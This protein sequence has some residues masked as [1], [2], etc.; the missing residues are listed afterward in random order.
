MVPIFFARSHVGLKRRN[1]EDAY[2][3]HPDGCV[4]AVA[5]GMGGAAA[6]EEA[7]RIFVET[8]KDVFSDLDPAQVPEEEGAR[9]VQKTFLWANERIL[10]HV[11]AHPNH[12]GMGCT[13]E[14]LAL[15]GS[16][17]VLGHMGDSRTYRVRNGQMRQLT[18][19]HSFV[20]E[21]V[22]EGLITADEARNHPMRN[23]VLR[24]VGVKRDPAVDLIRGDVRVGDRFLL[25]S[26]G[27]TDMVEDAFIESILSSADPLP[28]QVETLIEMA[29]SAG[30]KDNITVAI[31]HAS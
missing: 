14:V 4:G 23:V 22:D 24:A 6:G 8:A 3:L 20:Q 29:N 13:A 31:A 18:K 5:D 30:G 25:C 21:Q 2:V 16:R 1:N 27:L 9:L 12:K 26:D 15:F 7:S 19:D 10:D 28:Q 11:K 17:F